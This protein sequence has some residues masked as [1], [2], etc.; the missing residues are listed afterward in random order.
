MA[1]G[2]Q[3]PD[4]AAAEEMASSKLKMKVSGGSARAVSRSAAED[5]AMSRRSRF[6]TLLSRAKRVKL[7]ANC[8]DRFDGLS[9]AMGVATA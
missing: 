9:T 7:G 3:T 8:S 5:T 2:Q 1:S 4:D 6:A